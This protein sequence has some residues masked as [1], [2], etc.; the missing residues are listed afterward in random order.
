MQYLWYFNQD[1]NAPMIIDQS[2]NIHQSWP[3]SQGQQCLDSDDASNFDSNVKSDEDEI[4]RPQVSFATCCQQERDNSEPASSSS[5]SNTDSSENSDTES[6]IELNQN[7]NFNF[8]WISQAI[9]EIWASMDVEDLT[10]LNSKIYYFYTFNSTT[11][12]S[13]LYNIT[14]YWI[15]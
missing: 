7:D 8:W 2:S 11:T 6:D 3:P 12:Y 4:Q 10:N 15:W 9:Y 1:A 13:L 14:R 5:L